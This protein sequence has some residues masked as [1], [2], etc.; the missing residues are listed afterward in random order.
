VTASGPMTGRRLLHWADLD[1][2]RGGRHPWRQALIGAVLVT[3]LVAWVAHGSGLAAASRL[4]LAAA[5]A[6]TA[7]AMLGA[8]F[9]LYWRHDS[10][11]WARLPLPGD[12]LFHVAIMR[13]IRSAL[14]AAIIVG[15][16][17]AMIDPTWSSPELVLRHLALLAA[18]VAGAALL[19]PA[20]ALAGGALVASDK[21]ASLLA[22]LGGGE[23]QPPPTGWL[24]ALPGAT[25]AG[26]VLLGLASTSW[27][28]GTADETLI[29]PGEI[30]M[31]AAVVGAV[32]AAL[33]ARRAAV[34]VLPAALREVAALDR[35]QLAH[36]ELHPP[37]AIERAWMRLLPPAARVVFGKDARLMRRRYPLAYVIGAVGLLAQWI[38]AAVVPDGMLA[39]TAAIAAGLAVYA[40]VLARR[41][42]EPPIEHAIT[43][44][45]LPI[46]GREIALAKR[47]WWAL[48]LAV[49]LGAGLVA[50]LI[51]AATA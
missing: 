41:L 31:A 7:P 3:A 36:L 1:E 32:L 19:V 24:G 48:W 25:S 20:V 6:A 39:W 50:V 4:W 23:V 8:P 12:A 21:T 5:I 37:T 18:L 14:R 33:V 45:A 17:A 28:R 29:G 35:Q 49:Y 11:L 10:S 15:P 51:R 40:V 38:L 44:S 22:Q 47:G 42:A 26:L 30:V 13:S 2:R 34:T 16:A 46:T 43:L 27:L 9:R